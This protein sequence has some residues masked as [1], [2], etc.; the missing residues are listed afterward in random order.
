MANIRYAILG[1]LSRQPL[2]GYDLKRLFAESGIVHW[3][4]NNNQVYRTLLALHREG[5]LSVSVDAEGAGPVRKVY[6][7]TERGRAELRDWLKSPPELPELRHPLLV[8]LAW[9]DQLAPGEL[10]AL[11]ANYEDEVATQQQLLQAQGSDDNPARDS[12][13]VYLH[14]AGAR[15]P[16]EGY[17]WRMIWQRWIRF[18][19]AEL[20]WVR[21]ARSGLKEFGQ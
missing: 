20:D 13:E 10:E 17:L 14:P 7:V 15:T 4:G 8:Q 9:T 19:Q 3:S 5:A 16:R 1:A 21:Q 11:L 6:A 18:Y 2:S 12:G